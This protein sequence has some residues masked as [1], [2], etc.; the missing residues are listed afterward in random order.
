MKIFSGIQPSGVVHLGNYLG[1]MKN[2]ANLQNSPAGENEAIFCVVDYHA[3]TV[4]YPKDEMPQRIINAA[5]DILASGV[6]PNKSTL[7]LQSDIPEHTE[8]AWLLNTIT[9]MGELSRMTQYKDKTAKHEE[10][11]G[12]F[13]YPVLMAADIMIYKAEGV[14]VGEDQVQHVELTRDLVRRFNSKF[15]DTFPEPKPLLTEAKRVMSLSGS[16]KMSKSD[17]PSTYIAM[18]DEPDVIRKKISSAVTDDG[19]SDD[20][21]QSTINLI[22]LYGEFA[23]QGEADKFMEQ[24][25]AKTIK[26]S[27]F[28]P[29]LAEAIINE[30][31]PFQKRRAGVT[32]EEVKKIFT[33][34]AAKL[35]PIAQETLKE[36]KEKMGL[37]I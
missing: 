14:P 20:I 36:V 15:G 10:R 2:W 30:L 13:D 3:I 37:I 8:L 9:T 26:Y 12:L 16:G 11:A 28:K 6:D 18:T 19:Q 25:K 34:G 27:E 1:A 29:A 17:S 22:N 7:F 5:K 4:D 33:D 21:S 23:G 31:E 35:R 24:R 32:D